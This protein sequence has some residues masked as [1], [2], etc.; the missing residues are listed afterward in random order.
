M[1]PFPMPKAHE[2][3]KEPVYAAYTADELGRCVF[4]S[5]NITKGSLVHPGHP[6]TFLDSK[7]LT[8]F[9]RAV[10]LWCGFSP[11]TYTVSHRIGP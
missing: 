4:A 9:A 11:G 2:C 7:L 10:F 5:R 3:P 6:N 8:L 1:F